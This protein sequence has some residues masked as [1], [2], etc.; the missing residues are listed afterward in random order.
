MTNEIMVCC[1]QNESGVNCLCEFADRKHW[2]RL[3]D[4]S[5]TMAF[6]VSGGRFFLIQIILTK[7]LLL[8]GSENE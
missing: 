5:V 3:S 4:C 2:N 1:C 8:S 7:P 6:C